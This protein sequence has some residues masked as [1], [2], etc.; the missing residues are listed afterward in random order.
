MNAFAA[1]VAASRRT[2]ILR[3][4]VSLGDAANE[5]VIHIAT[6]QGGFAQATRDDIREDLD[7]LRARGCTTEK[8]FDDVVRVVTITERGEEA[9]YGRI[10]VAGVERS[11]WRR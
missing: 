9:A 1:A 10:E 2:F 6:T 3:L 5:S 8:W 11:S 4:L 7:L